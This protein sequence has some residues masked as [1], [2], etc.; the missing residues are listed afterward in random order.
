MFKRTF[1]TGLT[2]TVIA[3]GAMGAAV[4]PSAAGPHHHHHHGHRG[5]FGWGVGGFLLGAA[6]AQPRV[7]VV[8]E[9]GDSHVRRCSIRYRSYD[10]ASDT[11][12]GYDGYRHYCRL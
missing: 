4:Q 8:D 7:V 6:L 11:Y 1:V 2:A 12:M 10:P 9:Y 5:H 3:I